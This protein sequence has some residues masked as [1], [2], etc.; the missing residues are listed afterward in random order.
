MN[1]FSLHWLAWPSAKPKQTIRCFQESDHPS[2][3]V[4]PAEADM[5]PFCMIRVCC[6]RTEISHC[7]QLK[8][9]GIHVFIWENICMGLYWFH[10][11]LRWIGLNWHEVF[12]SP[13]GDEHMT[14]MTQGSK[15][16]F[17]RKVKG[18]M[19]SPI[20]WFH[21]WRLL[22]WVKVNNSKPI[23]LQSKKAP[24]IRSFLQDLRCRSPRSI[25]RKRGT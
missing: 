20:G 14:N 19:A 11:T 4:G 16:A 17:A 25:R 10:S 5:G 6:V 23:V 18:N 9:T 15:R 7:I 21:K 22:E 8:E 12:G 3:E 24:S 13:H 2:G 1:C